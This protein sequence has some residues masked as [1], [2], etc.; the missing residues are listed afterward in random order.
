MSQLQINTNTF[1]S[2][3]MNVLSF[4]SPIF[5]SI[6]GVQTKKMKQ[7]YP[8]KANQPEIQFNVQFTSEQDYE[9]FQK[10]VRDSQ[11]WSLAAPSPMV[12]LNWPERNI[13][14]WSGMIVG[15]MAGGMRGNY[16]PRASFTVSLFTS[17]V[18]KYTEMSSVGAVLE[19]AMPFLTQGGLSLASLFPNP[20]GLR[21]PAAIP[22]QGQDGL[23]LYRE[24]QDQNNQN[25]N[26][27]RNV[28]PTIQRPG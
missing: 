19:K 6:S 3:K 16:A 28:V 24:W 8:I 4:T 21:L 11:Q 13:N 27:P 14:N 12:Y 5:G 15:F 22:E 9:T 2:Y 10:F 20:F 23:R 7:W 25:P 18:S 1:G 26:S 17:F